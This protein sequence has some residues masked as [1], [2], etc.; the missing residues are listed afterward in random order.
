MSPEAQAAPLLRLESWGDW[1]TIQGST[2]LATPYPLEIMSIEELPEVALQ[3][4]AGCTFQAFGWAYACQPCN[5]ALHVS[6]A[7]M[8]QRIRHPPHPDHSLT[9]LPG[10]SPRI[11]RAHSTATPAARGRDGTGFSYHCDSCDI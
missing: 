1:A 5:Y 8:P 6:C 4:C 3:T 2:I 11:R 9:L 10:P 7:Q